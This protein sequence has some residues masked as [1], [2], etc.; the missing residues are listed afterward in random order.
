[1]FELQLRRPNEGDIDAM[2][3]IDKESF[4]VTS[5][6]ERFEEHLNQTTDCSLVAVIFK[7]KKKKHS[8]KR[9]TLGKGKVAG[10]L[11]YEV[12]TDEVYLAEIAVRKKSRNLG[13]GAKM[14]NWL[15]DELPAV[16][17]TKIRLYSTNDNNAR[18]YTR[19]GFEG[20]GGSMVYYASKHRSR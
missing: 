18:L 10:Y 11:L 15:I 3:A 12:E 5:K 16:N 19:V 8:K 1:N 9:K 6:R 14:L 20:G 4:A 7:K 13:I 2:M 17:R